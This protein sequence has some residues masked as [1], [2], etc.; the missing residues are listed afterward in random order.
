MSLDCSGLIRSLLREVQ[1]GSGLY[2]HMVMSPLSSSQIMAVLHPGQA[3]SRTEVKAGLPFS[4][5][6]GSDHELF[7]GAGEG[8]DRIQERSWAREGRYA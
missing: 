3:E 6:V 2:L 1:M 8:L 4:P 7:A 5:A